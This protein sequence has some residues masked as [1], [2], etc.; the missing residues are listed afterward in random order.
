M[1]SK[2]SKKPSLLMAILVGLSSLTLASIAAY[3]SV[4]GLTKLFPVAASIL[5]FAALEGSKLVTASLLHNHWS[6][7]KTALKTYLTIAVVALILITSAGL[8][9]FLSSAYSKTATQIEMVANANEL[10]DLTKK[11]LE[12]K[13]ANWQ[14]FI[15]TK[16]KRVQTLTEQRT[17]NL[18]RL[19]TLYNR[20]WWNSIKKTEKLIED[21]NID[22]DELN[23]EIDSLSNLQANAQQEIYDLETGKMERKQEQ[24]DNDTLTFV[25]ISELT[26]LPIDK[27][28]NILV[29][30]LVFIFDPLAVLL[31]VSFNSLLKQRR[32]WEDEN[33]E[34]EIP[35]TNDHIVLNKSQEIDDIDVVVHPPEDEVQHI[36]VIVKPKNVVE[37]IDLDFEV[38]PT[39]PFPDEPEPEDMKENDQLAG[40]EGLTEEERDLLMATLKTKRKA[41]EEEQRRKEEEAARLKAEEEERLKQ[42]EEARLKREEEIRQRLEEEEELK[43]KKEELERLEEEKRAEEERK[44]KE[45]AEIQEAIKKEEERLEQE[46]QRILSSVSE[47]HNLYLQILDVLYDGGNKTKGNSFEPYGMLKSTLANKGIDASEK[48][49]DDFLTVCALM[50]I[51]KVEGEDRERKLLKDYRRAKVLLSALSS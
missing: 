34:V 4:S 5:L 7:M 19:D 27:V 13:I 36:D 18:T 38:L 8:Y 26:G 17:Q 47:N 33:E 41:E 6:R 25:Y 12:G 43:R 30:I 29:I 49:F 39:Q 44:R 45:E 37:H 51:I 31:L 35:E 21:A 40:F 32:E 46:E 20:G 2:N 14:D 23:S 24:A 15:D 3:I 10:D 1:A 48:Q 42:E 22:I 28:I 50:R 9:S 11:D 16:D